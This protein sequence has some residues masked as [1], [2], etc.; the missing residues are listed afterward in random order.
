MGTS[1][2]YVEFVSNAKKLLA[3]IGGVDK[4][5]GRLGAGI[6]K[7]SRAFRNAGLGMAA[8]LGAA[9]KVAGDFDQQLANMNSVAQASQDELAEIRHLALKLGGA[10]IHGPRKLAEA[11]YWLASAG[12]KAGQ[13]MKTLP[14][15]ARLATATQFDLGQTPPIAAGPLNAF[16]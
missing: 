14:G 13:M 8:G 1:Q 12:Q 16:N 10:T 11:T 9:V 2:T 5:M 4:A 15:L 6:E 7:H 3:D